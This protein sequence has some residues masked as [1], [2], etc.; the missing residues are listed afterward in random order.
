[1]LYQISMKCG[2]C[3]SSFPYS[4]EHQEDVQSVLKEAVD[5]CPNCGS[6]MTPKITDEVYDI[7]DKQ[8]TDNTYDIPDAQAR[9]VLT[10]P[11]VQEAQGSFVITQPAP[12]F[13]ELPKREQPINR[14][15]E[16]GAYGV[17]NTELLALVLRQ[18]DLEA[19][20]HIREQFPTL[21][22][23]ARA[24][25]QEITQ[26]KGIGPQTAAALQASLELGRRL[27][28][29]A[30]P[31]KRQV[32]S[33]EDAAMIL[34][35]VISHQEQEHFVV[36]YLNTRNVVTD[37]EILY[38]G[39]LNTS[40]VRVGEVFRGAIRRNCAAIIVAHNHPSGDPEP[41]PEDIALTHRLVE[42]GKLLDIEVLDHLIVGTHHGF[43]SLRERGLGFEEGN[44]Q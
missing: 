11:T 43:V 26:I 42:A 32:R 20:M 19:A 41:S 44:S 6:T 22:E 21:A 18:S 12:S 33:P 27:L 24:S 13:P 28:N 9:F 34:T 37:E 36:L 8:A 7:R 15:R 4:L 3:G 16:V 30:L 5:T 29:E 38:K 31:N 17:S 25:E 40:V 14:L 10:Q 1:M 23:L 2:L 39:S 35:P